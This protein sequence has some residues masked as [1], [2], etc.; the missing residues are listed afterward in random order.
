M[1][2]RVEADTS[3]ALLCPMPGLVKVI[4]VSVGQAV[5]AGEPLCLVEAMKMENV[6]K[7]ERDVTV[8]TIEAKPGESLAVDAVIMTFD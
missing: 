4:N 2:E 7:A 1:R 5:K 6:L 8:K 3:K